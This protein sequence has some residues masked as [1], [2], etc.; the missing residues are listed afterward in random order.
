MAADRA[1]DALALVQN[2]SGDDHK[3]KGADDG[4]VPRSETDAE[5]RVSAV[6]MPTLNWQ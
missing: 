4:P 1:M 6:S 5:P 3:N 2:T